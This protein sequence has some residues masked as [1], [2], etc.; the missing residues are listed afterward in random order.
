MNF[1]LVGDMVVSR[2][3]IS[4]KDYNPKATIPSYNTI[5]SKV[6]TQMEEFL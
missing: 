1:K 6:I 3:V 4:L 5:P 2:R